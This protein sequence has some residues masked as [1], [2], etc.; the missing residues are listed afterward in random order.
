MRYTIMYR[1]DGKTYL[2]QRTFG[3]AS[4]ALNWIHAAADKYDSFSVATI[5]KTVAISSSQLISD[6]NDEIGY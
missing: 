2:H 4:D 6:A 3:L 5:Y 1:K